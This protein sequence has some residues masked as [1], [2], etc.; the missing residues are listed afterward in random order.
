M[1]LKTQV[2]CFQGKILL[3]KVRK[4][5]SVPSHQEY[6]FGL[7]TALPRAI[8]QLIS[9]VSKRRFTLNKVNLA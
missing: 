7:G 2:F 1:R 9:G 4:F 6:D 8:S 5:C 3:A